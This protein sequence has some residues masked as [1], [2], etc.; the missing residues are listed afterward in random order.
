MEVKADAE[1]L[2][3][4]GLGERIRNIAAGGHLRCA[5]AFW[6]ESGISELFPDGVPNDV[7]VV[8]DIAMGA[9]SAAALTALG[10]PDNENVKHSVRMHAKIFLSDSGM[11]ASSAN[12]SGSALG[13]D[14]SGIRNI[15][16]GVFHPANSEA[17][18]KASAWFNKLFRSASPIGA[19]EVAWAKLLFRRHPPFSKTGLPVSGSL[20]E[21]VVAVPDKF[22]GIGFVFANVPTTTE[23]R[24]ETRRDAVEIARVKEESVQA[25]PDSG[26]F[27]GWGSSFAKKWPVAFIEFWQPHQSLRVYGRRLTVRLPNT[28]GGSIMSV[29]D[30][31]GVKRIADIDWPTVDQIGPADAELSARIRNAG[32]NFFGNGQELADFIAR[33]ESDDE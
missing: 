15:E 21:M 9:T 30:W 2:C 5:V 22:S 32:G 10:A 31:P 18:R 16:A 7:K 1:F 20:L 29:N 6:S 23:Q 3:G 8:L 13:D 17:W 33:M 25:M 4:E 27:A 26:I 28:E 11:V 14:D 19:D 24:M 12:A